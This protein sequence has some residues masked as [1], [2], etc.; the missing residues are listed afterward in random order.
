ML[1]S[2]YAA[3]LVA[4]WGLCLSPRG[5]RAQSPDPTGQGTVAGSGEV[6]PDG[7][8]VSLDELLA[9]A[10]AHAP[11]VRLATA[12]LGLGD[13]AMAE[14][15]PLLPANPQVTF[16]AGPGINSPTHVDFTAS[17]SQRIEVAGERGLR[18]ATAGR[19]RTRLRAELAEVRWRVHSEVHAAF[20]DTLVAR[21][22]LSAAQRV[23]AFQ[24]RLLEIAHGRL[25]AGDV[26][27]LITR[28]AE[29][30][31]SQA[32]VALIEARQQYMQARLQVGVLA[33][34]SNEQPLTPTGELDAPRDPPAL[35]ALIEAAVVSQPRLRTLEARRHE[36]RSA[37]RL[38][39]RESWPE[40]TI[41]LQLNRERLPQGPPETQIMGVLSVPIP[42]ARRNLGGRARARAD[43]QIAE[44]ERGTFEAQL[45]MRIEAHR[46]EVLA[47]AAQVRTYGSEILPTF[48]ENLRLI[49]RAFELGEIDILQVSVARERFLRIQADAL[50][51]YAHYFQAVAK[52]EGAI[53]A[54]LWPEERHEHS[55]GVAPGKEGTP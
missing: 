55:T 15:S 13:A 36:A 47:A 48:E 53:G 20:H 54:D 23:L 28:L 32:R 2:R 3:V 11:A 38:Q 44:A 6:A 27:P 16:G 37:Q 29:G 1:A 14:A 19:T 31:L 8:A 51:A 45:R 33:G 46:S 34:W 9:H 52:L 7:M 26:S 40:P 24:E 39:E 21:E 5:T 30:E 35:S 10:D 41:K 18:V 4:L 49:R 12:R 17:L 43:L 25:R 50:G 42:V 22:R